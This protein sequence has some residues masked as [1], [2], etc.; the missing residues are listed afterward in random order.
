MIRTT[1][2]MEQLYIYLGITSSCKKQIICKQYF[3][4][5]YIGWKPVG[6]RKFC[7][8]KKFPHR[9]VE[10]VDG[11]LATDAFLKQHMEYT[12]SLVLCIYH[13][14][15]EVFTLKA[16]DCMVQ[17]FVHGCWDPL[18]DQSVQVNGTTQELWTHKHTTHTLLFTYI[19]FIHNV[20]RLK[21]CGSSTPVCDWSLYLHMSLL[22]QCLIAVRG[23]IRDNH[24]IVLTFC[25]KTLVQENTETNTFT[26]SKHH[27]TN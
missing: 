15:C 21:Y 9:T 11:N 1:F 25:S 5:W 6:V 16:A 24:S 3:G 7:K 22:Q 13:Y 14:R 27:L 20:L 4:I 12:H 17:G 26:H 8:K 10:N 2:C 19:I 23:G 18:G